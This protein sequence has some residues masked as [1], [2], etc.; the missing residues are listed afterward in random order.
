MSSEPQLN[1]FKKNKQT[2]IMLDKMRDLN[3]YK[4]MSGSS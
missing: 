1:N 2:K 4:Q 3:D